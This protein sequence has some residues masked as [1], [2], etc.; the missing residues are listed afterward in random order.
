ML[1]TK[2]LTSIEAALTHVRGLK[3][4]RWLEG[5]CARLVGELLVLEAQKGHQGSV[6]TSL[7]LKSAALK[8]FLHLV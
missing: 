3:A 1:R 5:V 6:D 8:Y 4:G 2:S 7:C